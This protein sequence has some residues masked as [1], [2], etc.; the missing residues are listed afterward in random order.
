MR[1]SLLNLGDV[2]NRILNIKG[3]NVDISVNRGRKKID[4]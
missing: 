2:K 1:K 3:K 4:I